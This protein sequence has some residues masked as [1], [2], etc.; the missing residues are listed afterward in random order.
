MLHDFLCLFVKKMEFA[1]VSSGK[2]HYTTIAINKE[3]VA[4][5]PPPYPVQKNPKQNKQTIVHAKSVIYYKW[6]V[7]H[8][9]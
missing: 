6:S 8:Y 5:L 4:H 9:L 2:F 7:S 1:N 3:G